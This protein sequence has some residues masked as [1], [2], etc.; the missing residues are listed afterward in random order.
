MSP[1]AGTPPSSQ[2][3]PYHVAVIMDGNG[4]WAKRQAF[5][6]T[7]GHQA[8]VVATREVVKNCRER[9]IGILTIFAFSSENWQ[10]PA[11]EVAFLVEL[12]VK[13][14]EEELPSLHANAVRMRFIGNID[15]FP[16]G[17][18][19]VIRRAE[20]TTAGNKGMTLVI[21]VGYGGRWDILQAAR[22]MALDVQ[23]G[24]V[25]AQQMDAQQFAGYLQLGDLPDPDLLIRTGCEHRVSNF[26]LWHLAYSELYFTDT[27]WPDFSADDLDQALAWFATRERRFGR[28]K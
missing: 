22:R 20:E 1:N 21:A 10:R 28:V 15:A 9:G 27:L 6:R 16:P 4:R 5:E 3:L 14:V 13:T 8:G 26:L 24:L 19:D 11:A 18:R 23:T 25:N 12:F 7:V 2:S 17:F